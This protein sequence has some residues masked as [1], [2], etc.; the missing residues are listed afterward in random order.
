MMRNQ[1]KWITALAAVAL[2]GGGALAV[3][4]AQHG[5]GPLSGVIGPGHRG[6]PP[7]WEVCDLNITVGE[8]KEQIESLR[9]ERAEQMYERCLEEHD[10]EFCDERRAEME[11]NGPRR[12]GGPAHGPHGPR[13]PGGEAPGEG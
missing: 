13:G 3:Q 5:E 6:P 8:C 10:A 9:E 4:A 1:T 7:I 2:I 12:P 11:E